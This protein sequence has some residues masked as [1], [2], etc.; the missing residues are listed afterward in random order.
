MFGLFVPLA[1]DGVAGFGDVGR[2]V[3]GVA[4]DAGDAAAVGVEVGNFDAH[5]CCD[6]EGDVR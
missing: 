2:G 1:G 5:V 3:A 6:L 4:A